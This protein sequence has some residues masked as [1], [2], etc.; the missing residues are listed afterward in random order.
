MASNYDDVKVFHFAMGLPLPGSPQLLD[1]ETRKF[2]EKFMHEELDEFHGAC[3]NYD[4]AGAADALVDLVY[5]AMGTAAMMGLP[6]QELWDEVQRA[7]MAKQRA[8]P[9]GSDS[10]RGS[11]L[12]VVKPMGWQPPDIK[13]VLRKHGSNT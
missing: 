1:R 13:G 3:A 6:W 2:R 8:L 9:D 10:K 12:D 5:V 11:S 4:L 7:N